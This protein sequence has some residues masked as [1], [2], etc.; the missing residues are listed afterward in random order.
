MC[1]LFKKNSK[2]VL[3]GLILLSCCNASFA[4]NSEMNQTLVQ[5]VNQLNALLPLIT[6]AQKQQDKNTPTQFHFQT[7]TDSKGIQHAGLRQDI[8]AI[9]QGLLDQI[10][11]APLAPRTVQPIHNDFVGP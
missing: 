1:K 11:Q 9:R 8:L 5:M 4:G 2:Y 10:N 7:W 6:E 3:A